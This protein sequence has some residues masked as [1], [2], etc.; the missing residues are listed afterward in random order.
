MLDQLEQRDNERTRLRMVRER[1]LPFPPEPV[2][3][4]GINATRWSLDRADH[5]RGRRNLLLKT[6]DAL[7]LGFDS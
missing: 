3:A 5:E 4:L 7:G 6:L 2:A 1:P